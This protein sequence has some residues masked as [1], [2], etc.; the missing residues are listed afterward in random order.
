MSYLP[1]TLD[2]KALASLLYRSE[3]TIIRDVTRRPHTLPPFIRQGK[4]PIW[5][6]SV[7][8]D[9]LLARLSEP[10]DI[11]P[12]SIFATQVAAP[13][14]MPSLAEMMMSASKQS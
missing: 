9:W 12:R 14:A 6:T 8:V 2:A 11:D 7:V 5:I 1:P 13:P 10:I 4:K 3:T